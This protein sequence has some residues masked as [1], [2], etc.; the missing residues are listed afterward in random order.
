MRSRLSGFTKQVRARISFA[1]LFL[2]IVVG[3]PIH[4][5]AD[6]PPTLDPT[7]RLLEGSSAWD[8][9]DITAVFDS[10]HKI[11]ARY[12]ITNMGPGTM[13]AFA[14]GH[15]ILPNGEKIEWENGRTKSGWTLSDD[16]MLIDIGRSHL[17]LEGPKFHHFVNKLH[18]E[19]D[20]RFPAQGQ[21]DAAPLDAVADYQTQTLALGSPVKGTIRLPES[22][23][24][25]TEITGRVFMIHRWGREDQ[26][27]SLRRSIELFYF[28]DDHQG[29]VVDITAENG[30]R[31]TWI[32]SLDENPS[33]A[34]VR[35]LHPFELDGVQDPALGKKYWVPKSIRVSEHQYLIIS[36]DKTLLSDNPLKILPQPFRFIASRSS[37]PRRLWASV[38]DEWGRPTT[39]VIAA[40][41][42]MNPLKAPK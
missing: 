37:K 38:N 30:K 36:L 1:A 8:H 17:H 7:P 31:E 5:S 3:G 34:T 28:G 32:E 6:A 14:I 24:A 33:F 2:T 12:M 27:D 41:I 11:F 20:F 26:E 19:I 25:P 22:E 13:N 23:N 18:I 21:T 15:V 40:F 35:Q 16:R 39:E 42:F 4:A 10:G 29:R 9:Y